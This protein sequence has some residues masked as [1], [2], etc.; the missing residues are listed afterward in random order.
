VRIPKFFVVPYCAANHLPLCFRRIL[1]AILAPTLLLAGCGSST[2]TPTTV[3][4]SAL[5]YPQTAITVVVGVAITTDT[6]TVLGSSP[7][8]TVTPALPAGLSISATTGAISGTPTSVASLATYIITASNSAGVTTDTLP[9]T[10]NAAPPSAL[11]YPQTTINA[12]V[13]TAI[14][15][16]TPTFLGTTPVFGV[17]PTLPAGLSINSTTGAISGTPTVVTATAT[18][19]VTASNSAGSITSTL[20]ITVGLAPTLTY[21]SIVGYLNNPIVYDTPKYTGPTATFSIAPALPAGLSINSTTGLISGTP[22]VITPLTNYIATATS[23]IGSTTAPLTIQVVY[24]PPYSLTYPQLTITATVGIPVNPDTPTID[25]FE[26]ITFTTSPV[27]PA[28]LTINATTGV[29]SGTPTVAATQTN[30]VV[31]AT[32]SGGTTQ[33]TISITVSAATRPPSAFSYP[34]NPIIAVIGDLLPSDIPNITGTATSFTVTPALP[35]GIV[36]NASTGVISGSPTTAVAQATYTVTATGPLGNT[37]AT[38]QI[39]VVGG[40]TMLLDLGHTQAISLLQAA[41]TRT[42]SQDYSGRWV[43]SNFTTS[44]LISEGSAGTSSGGSAWPSALAGSVVAIGVANGV[45]IRSATDAH[46]I[47]TISS[48]VID[49]NTATSWWMLS[50]DGNYVVS[51]STAGLAIWSTTSGSLLFNEYGDYSTAK[52]FASPT[53]VTIGLGPAGA[54]VIETVA[55][56]TFTSTTGP[57]FSGTFVKWFSDGGNFITQLSNTVWIYSSASVQQ[58]ILSTTTV[59]TDGLGNYFWSFVQSQFTLTLYIIGS[60]SPVGTYSNVSYESAVASGGTIGLFGRTNNISILNLSTLGLSTYA[61]PIEPFSYA[62]TSPS[63]WVVGDG[64]GVVADTPTSPRYFTLGAATGIAGG[65]ADAAIATATGT[66]YEFNPSVTTPTGTINFPSNGLTLST[67]GTVLCAAGNSNVNIYSLPGNSTLGS[68]G[69]TGNLLNFSLSGSGTVFSMLVQPS[70]YV[71]LRTVQQVGG[72][73]IWS[74]AVDDGVALSPDGTY[75][76]VTT[77]SSTNGATTQILLNGTL[78]NAVT[79]MV[80]GWLDS[81]HFLANIYVGTREPGFTG[82]TIYNNSGTVSG[83][84]LL[85]DVINFQPVDSSDVYVPALNQILSVTSATPTWTGSLPSTEGAVSG[86]YVVYVANAHVYAESR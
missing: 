46:L 31:S 60:A 69:Y 41:S 33:A 82:A 8:F 30:Y 75:I 58:S 11:V 3:T 2:P 65:T 61:M 86:S 54:N 45:D 68:Y 14:A 51:G 17:S 21:N 12:T 53:Q 79:G 76:G 49:S 22:T 74:E 18:Y 13:N 80:V 47:L 23:S 52:A 9:I 43:L 66:I 62:A 24:N 84:S 35:A 6:P 32:N 5:S 27:L 25:S 10:V 59:P 48:P 29:I 28:G 19:T 77:P 4:P 16:D 81:S 72:G 34:T 85:N 78:T 38:I 42:L 71:Y 39:T 7:T 44:A 37:T 73:T 40:L 57:A 20:S 26:G 55:T 1:V 83:T 50:T 64:R 70:T 15:T 63:Q 36:L 56:A 67:D